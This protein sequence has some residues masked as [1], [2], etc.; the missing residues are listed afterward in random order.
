MLISPRNIKIYAV[1]FQLKALNFFCIFKSTQTPPPLLK[2]IHSMVRITGDERLLRE[3]INAHRQVKCL[4]CVLNLN[5]KNDDD[6]ENE[7]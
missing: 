1:E 3:C 5:S 4:L 2:F 6:D 7:K